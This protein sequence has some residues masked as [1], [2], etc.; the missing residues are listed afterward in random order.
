MEMLSRTYS[1]QPSAVVVPI[2]LFVGLELFLSSALPFRSLFFGNITI[3]AVVCTI[4][5]AVGVLCSKLHLQV[6]DETFCC[7]VRFLG[8]TFFRR[9]VKGLSW[10]PISFPSR[11]VDGGTNDFTR[12][13]VD[14]CTAHGKR[15]LA[16]GSLL[17]LIYGVDCL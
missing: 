1:A 12:Y 13:R 8:L 10:H 14:V 4:L 7:S 6:A 2:L 5:F 3:F 16:M 15:V 17:G 9:A 11:S